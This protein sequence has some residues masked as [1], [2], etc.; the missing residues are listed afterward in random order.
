MLLWDVGWGGEAGP[1]P[2]GTGPVVADHMQ[3]CVNGLCSNYLLQ[4]DYFVYVFLRCCNEAQFAK[5][6]LDP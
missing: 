2:V 1:P 5:D 6:S 3:G 4:L